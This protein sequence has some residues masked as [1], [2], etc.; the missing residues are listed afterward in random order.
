MTTDA[1]PI[2][3]LRQ[4]VNRQF[5]VSSIRRQ[6]PV[7]GFTLIELL[8][9]IAIIA[10]LAAMLLPA[11]SKAKS[12]AHTARCSANMKQWGCA[13]VMYL[14]DYDDRLPYMADDY[15]FTLPFLFQKLAPYV[16]R[17]TQEGASFA[18]ADVF[19]SDL[20][21]CPAG[22]SAPP[23]FATAA[24]TSWNCWVGAHFGGWGNPLSGPFYYG[25]P[26]NP[27]TPCLKASRIKKPADA[28]TFMDTLT[29]YVYSP[30]DPDYQFDSDKNHD[31]MVDSHEGAD[32]GFAFNDGR[33]T[34]HNNGD[35]VTLLDGHVEWV[36]FKKLWQVNAARKVVHSFWYLED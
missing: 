9:V 5:P 7:S 19:R 29:H 12:R 8:V 3:G 6:F 20:R 11:L 23:P 25:L 35:N 31:G 14:M 15:V 21:K 4:S 30:A 17:P 1:R 10:I 26:K 2:L 24:W 36:P 18:E 27:P 32:A 22:S 16:A 33:P 13:T 28:M 34:V